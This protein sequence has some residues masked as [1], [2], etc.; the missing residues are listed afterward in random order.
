MGDILSAAG[1]ATPAIA[2]E[3]RQPATYVTLMAPSDD[4]S[5]ELLLRKQDT[6]TPSAAAVDVALGLTLASK[7]VVV[8][9]E[10]WSFQFV[11]DSVAA[12]SVTVRSIPYGD[13]FKLDGPSL[14]A[15]EGAFAASE[16]LIAAALVDLAGVVTDLEGDTGGDSVAGAITDIEAVI[17]DLEG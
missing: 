10:G 9:P 14:F 4:W 3:N 1:N 17:A 8:V 15:A 12:G 5:G 11:A 13:G 16:A 2:N 6:R 7:Y